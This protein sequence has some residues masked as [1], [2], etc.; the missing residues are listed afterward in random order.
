MQYSSWYEWPSFLHHVKKSVQKLSS[1]LVITL[2]QYWTNTTW[3]HAQAIRMH[4]VKAVHKSVHWQKLK[5][6]QAIAHILQ[7]MQTK[8]ICILI[9]KVIFIFAVFSKERESTFSVSLLS[10]TGNT[11]ENYKKKLKFPLCFYKFDRIM[12]NFLFVIY[13]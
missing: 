8:R 7:I 10:Y 6:A 4:M 9:I 3:C 12:E 13:M 2:I 5:L 11:C 1:V